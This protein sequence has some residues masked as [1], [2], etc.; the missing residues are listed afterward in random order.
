MDIR[1]DHA[2][3]IVIRTIT[4]GPRGLPGPPAGVV[5]LSGT[6]D[7]SD[8][9][10]GEMLIGTCLAGK[11]VFRVSVVID[12]EFDGGTVLEIGDTEGHA[13]LMTSEVAQPG[14]AGTTF[15]TT[16]DHRYMDNT[17]VYIYFPAGTPTTGSGRVIIYS[18]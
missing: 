6:F 12:S 10:A 5:N 13:R 17:D 3:G 4:Q 15:R 11:Y 18:F 9:A 1:K 7:F 14:Y 16:P 2:R 8:V